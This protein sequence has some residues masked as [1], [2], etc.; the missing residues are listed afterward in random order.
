MSHF[1]DTTGTKQGRH[2]LKERLKKSFG[3]QLVFLQ[4]ENNVPQVVISSECLHNRILSRN[5][6]CIEQFI[7]KRA[8][9][10][11]QESV[12]H[13][14][15]N[16]AQLPWPPTVESFSARE[17]HYPELLES[18]C[19]ELLSNKISHTTSERVG[20]LTD[21]FCQDIVHAV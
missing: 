16:V 1:N 20:R 11:L 5:S 8:A 9:L 3:D 19:K 10:M 13:H 15:E 7:I 6:P 17:R 21:S 4:A 18:F 14:L 12:Q 2:Q